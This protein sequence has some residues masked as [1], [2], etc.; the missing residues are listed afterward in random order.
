MLKWIY[1][2]IAS[3]RKKEKYYDSQRLNECYL[4]IITIISI[5]IGRAR[6]IYVFCSI[7]WWYLVK[8]ILIPLDYFWVPN[9]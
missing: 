8:G 2:S 6:D 4:K 5:G 9:E 7:V 3:V 1:L